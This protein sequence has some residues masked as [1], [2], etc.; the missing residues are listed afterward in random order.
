MNFRRMEKRYIIIE[1][2]LSF[3]FSDWHSL[4]FTLLQSVSKHQFFLAVDITTRRNE[5][6]LAWLLYTTRSTTTTVITPPPKL[7]PFFSITTAIYFLPFLTFEFIFT[8]ADSQSIE[9]NYSLSGRF[10][11][12]KAKR[13]YAFTRSNCCPNT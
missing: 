4:T 10:I 2:T 1:L 3:S 6:S 11:I 8:L 12:T 13:R 5:T 7:N 9:K